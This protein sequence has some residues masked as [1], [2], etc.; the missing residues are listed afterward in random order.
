MLDADLIRRVAVRAAETNVL[1][2]DVIEDACRAYL[3]LEGPAPRGNRKRRPEPVS[4]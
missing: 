3:G 2:R 1:D 4:A